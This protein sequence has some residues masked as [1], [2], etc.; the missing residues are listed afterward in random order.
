MNS[1]STSRDKSKSRSLNRTPSTGLLDYL[2][3]KYQQS[4]PL[5]AVTAAHKLYGQTKPLT[6]E[7]RFLKRFTDLKGDIDAP[8]FVDYLNR[9]EPL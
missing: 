9:N 8:K 5:V 3:K 4:I 1:K 2:D 6:R 7:D